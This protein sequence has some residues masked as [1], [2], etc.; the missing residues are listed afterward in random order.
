MMFLVFN[1]CQTIFTLN[2]VDV[3]GAGIRV[4]EVILLNIFLSFL[5]F[6][7]ASEIKRYSMLWSWTALGIGIFQCLR[8][9]LIP[10]SVQGK[11]T[12]LII[13][14]SLEAAGFLLIIASVWSLIKCGRYRLAKKELS[15][16]T[17]V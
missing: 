5:A 16:H 15:C 11:S 4:M 2:A 3:S 7:A 1:T 14:L 9:F 17:S 13:V 12:E 10:G 6:I 8:Y